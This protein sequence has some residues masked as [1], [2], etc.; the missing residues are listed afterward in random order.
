MTGPMEARD[1]AVPIEGLR[2]AVELHCR[3]VLR[4]AR[5]SYLD[6]ASDET[7]MPEPPRIDDLD[8]WQAVGVDYMAM[9]AQV[10]AEVPCVGCGRLA[11]GDPGSH[12]VGCL[13][14]AKG[15]ADG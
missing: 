6:A 5:E 13:E 11:E 14:A 3:R 10:D 12:L 15:T 9:R 8:L 4:R 2:D 7:A 1:Q